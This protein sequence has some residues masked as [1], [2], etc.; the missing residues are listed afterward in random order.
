MGILKK[1]S[2]AILC[3]AL[4]AGMMLAD[5]EL[6]KVTI[7]G[8][9]FYFYE[10]DK[11]ETL[12]QIAAKFGWNVQT[13]QK[14]NSEVI[15]KTSKGTLIYYPAEAKKT[16]SS[17]VSY[18]SGVSSSPDI[19]TRDLYHTV[20]AGE[21]AY[22]IS[23]SYNIP[24]DS[25][26]ALNP[27]A[28]KGIQKG[29]RLLIQ[30]AVHTPEVLTDQA[31]IYHT[32]KEG[33]S[34]YGIANQYST[35]IDELFRSNPGLKAGTPRVGEIIRITRT[36]DAPE[37]KRELVEE[38]QLDSLN[39]Y[40]AKRGDSWESIAEANNLTVDLIK[41]ANP[42]KDKI[43]KGDIIRIPVVKTVN[44]MKEYVTEDP[45]TKNEEGVKEIY[46]EVHS[47]S[48]TT[49]AG[50]I[51]FEIPS[52]GV[53]I[54]LSESPA[55][56]DAK[57]VNNNKNME[58]S[59]GALTALDVLKARPFK[60]RLTIIDGNL[61]N[62]SIIT[63]LNDFQPNLIVSTTDNQLPSYLLEYAARN[64][65]TM[66]M[67]AFDTK[68][69]GYI[70]NANILQYMVP[71]SYMHTE[72]A[73]YF[74]KAY[75]DYK[76]LIAGAPDEKDQLGNTIIRGFAERGSDRAEEIQIEEL[77]NLPLDETGKYLIYCNAKEEREV[78][79]L[80][81]KINNL[82]L[83]Y[84]NADI[85]VI[86]RPEWIT[87]VKELRNEF[88]RAYANIPTRFFFDPEDFATNDFI[89]RYHSYFNTRPIKAA[90]SYGATAYDIMTYFVPNLADAKG[91][92]N[93]GFEAY[94]TL[95]I[96]MELERVSNWGGM[97]NKAVYVVNFTPLGTADRIKLPLS[98]PSEE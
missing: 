75:S 65:S 66:L 68:S 98:L 60:T 6:P 30:R 41:E 95:Q 53:A 54:V 31:S 81:E 2:G 1:L 13:L 76:L 21:T 88:G 28:E 47:L 45:R 10:A 42:G 84:L 34:L 74:N 70:D 23:R 90:P 83:R 27:S 97:V 48:G 18:A 61:A 32:V 5:T 35:T 25:L 92:F 58:F 52:V 7:L 89:E 38:K 8:R 3:L 33:E 17:H 49:D 73:D 94:P 59:R 67:S 72:V 16:S 26:Y 86:G 91:D 15:G 46:N 43:N 11:G 56:E 44:V 64:N 57:R 40:V 69:E 19:S 22:G 78:R 29:E 77:E 71:S 51:N 12:D 87:M 36:A 93:Q 39:Q 85:R 79:E 20:K 14:T 24:L 55:T 96:P 4:G 62:D 63:L 37:V 50:E 80:L 82:K 9:T